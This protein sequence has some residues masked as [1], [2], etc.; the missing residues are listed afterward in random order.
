[1]VLT[2]AIWFQRQSEAQRTKRLLIFSLE[3]VKGRD[4]VTTDEDRV[5]E[6]A[7][8]LDSALEIALPIVVYEDQRRIGILRIR[9]SAD[10]TASP[11]TLSATRYC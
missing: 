1:M 10:A 8:T 4:K 6:E 11:A 7:R 5:L 2:K 9:T 3:L